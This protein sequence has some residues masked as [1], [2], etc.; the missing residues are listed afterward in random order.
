MPVRHDSTID[1]AGGCANY[2]NDS[3]SLELLMTRSLHSTSSPVTQI[4]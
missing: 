2:N 3:A 4:P 1:E